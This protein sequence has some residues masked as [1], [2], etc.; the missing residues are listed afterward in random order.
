MS[1]Y[2]YC[3][4]TD[5]AICKAPSQLIYQVEIINPRFTGGKSQDAKKYSHLPCSHRSLKAGPT[6]RPRPLAPKALF[7]PL[8]FWCPWF[9]GA[10]ISLVNNQSRRSSLNG[11]ISQ[12]SNDSS[13][14][15]RN[16][17]W[18]SRGGDAIKQWNLKLPLT[19]CLGGKQE[20]GPRF[21]PYRLPLPISVSLSHYW[22]QHFKQM[23]DVS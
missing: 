19:T 21:F 18:E 1:L 13:H 11:D 6:L 23:N 2:L 10:T 12:Q 7:F 22:S 20:M 4:M 16:N 8:A 3:T 9:V 15:S 5:T 14:T 17:F